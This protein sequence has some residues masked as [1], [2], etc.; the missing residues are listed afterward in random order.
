MSEECKLCTQNWQCQILIYMYH[1]GAR[2]QMG[3]KRTHIHTYGENKLS[4]A[5]RKIHTS[6]K[7][8]RPRYIDVMDNF[9]ETVVLRT[10]LARDR[11][12]FHKLPEKKFSGKGTSWDD[13]MHSVLRCSLAVNVAN[14]NFIFINSR[15]NPLALYFRLVGFSVVPTCFLN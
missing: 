15:S 7:V 11:I 8:S 9:L 14:E 12:E 10:R 13:S 1:Y 6:F 4:M 2:I 5:Q 3:N